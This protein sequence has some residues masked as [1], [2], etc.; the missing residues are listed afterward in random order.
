MSQH[1]ASNE[2]VKAIESQ[3]TKANI[4]VFCMSKSGLRK[5]AFTDSTKLSYFAAKSSDNVNKVPTHGLSQPSQDSVPG[6]KR[7]RFA[8]PLLPN[9]KKKTNTEKK[10]TSLITQ[11]NLIKEKICFEGKGVEWKRI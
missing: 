2:Y 10:K 7:S 8:A 6:K 9:K 4:G 11:I 3:A 1:S 5:S